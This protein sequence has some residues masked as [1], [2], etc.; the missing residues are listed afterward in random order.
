MLPRN[1]PR[2][3][4]VMIT[5]PGGALPSGPTQMKPRGPHPKLP[6]VCG[7]LMSSLLPMPGVV[8]GALGVASVT[9]GA[10]GAGADVS[11]C[12]AGIGRSVVAAATAAAAVTTRNLVAKVAINPPASRMSSSLPK[13]LT[14]ASHSPSLL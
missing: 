2:N 11:A 8:D 10:A 3:G 14:Q 4:I 7:A 6:S 12:A 13:K 9:T 5:C 1:H